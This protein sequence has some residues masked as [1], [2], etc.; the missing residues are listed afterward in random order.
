MT[1]ESKKETLG[2]Q[3][4][5]K[6]LLHLMIHSMYSNK[7]IF[8]RELVS[9]ASDASDKLRFEAIAQP[10]LLEDQPDLRIRI[11]S[12]D[13]ANTLTI[14]DNGI[15]MSRQE[16]ID[17]L[18]TIAKSG[19]AAFMQQL[20]GDQ[21]KDA[22]LIGQFGVG[23]YSAFIVADKVE[24]F[25]RR[26]G[27]DAAEG[28]HWESA[29]EGEFSI[30]TVEKPERG[31]RIVL[32]LKPAESEFADGFR[33]RNVVT[34][35][36]DHI[37]LPIELPKQHHGEEA[38]KPAETE[39]ESVNR[40]SALWTRPRTE[41]K[42]EEYQEFYK[43]VAHDFENPLSWSHNKVEGKLEY[44][45][46]LYVPGRAPFDLYQ[47]EAPRGLKL[48]VQRV[49]IMDDAEQFLPL[50]LRFIKGVVDSNDLSLNVSREILQKD[51][52]IDS[53]KSALTKRTLDM[54]G[55]LAKNEPEQYANFWKA[56]GSV[57]K[58]GPAE[59]YANREKVASLLRFA[60][61]QQN[62]DSEVVSLDTYIE[63]M[64]EGQDKI[65]YLTGE[66]YNQVKNSPHLEIFRKK[67]IEV[68]LLTDRIDEWLMSHLTEYNGKQFIDIARGDLDLG[69]LEGEE[70]K[71]AQEKQAEA[72]ADLVKRIQEA[73]KDELQE[74]RVSHRLT[75]S[76]AVLVINEDDMGLQM[77]KILE[78]T[79]QKAPESKPILE[80]NT[81]HPLL[82]KLDNEQDEARFADLSQILFDQAALAAGEALQDPAAYV[83]RLN[84]LLVELSS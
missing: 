70:D 2:F 23:F 11:S 27:L 5:V 71:Q 40:A 62:D 61:T 42:D 30:A 53:M 69:K 66:R 15:G 18:G 81:S 12:D 10:E 47:R 76:P 68:L 29:G 64:V 80:I 55:K 51:P 78:A 43:H 60:S 75:D 52:A 35:Y 56:F 16:V 22:S 3:T 32:H 58:E 73:L 4:E 26:A 37:S 49:F 50:Y 45:S 38:E 41:V 84:A 74:V 31:T 79:G 59:D 72:K 17:H 13:K 21:K 24:V 48:Y 28:V 44:T 33:L 57:L 67:G 7:E 77:R 82:D 83:R 20:S 34:K 1:V 6:Q 39:W 36:S 46:L 9:N 63:R 65:Y 14:E 25:T 8:L 54:L 19:T